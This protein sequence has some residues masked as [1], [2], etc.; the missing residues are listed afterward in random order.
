MLA[1][2]LLQ[3]AHKRSSW[4]KK[5]SCTVLLTLYP[6]GEGTDGD[7]RNDAD[8]GDEERRADR[9]NG[10]QRRYDAPAEIAALQ[11]NAPSSAPMQPE[12]MGPG[13]IL[14]PKILPRPLL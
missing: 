7:T 3:C 13:T 5:S 10:K 9:E 12:T 6:I 2:Q 4:H 14:E 8:K 1:C 11:N